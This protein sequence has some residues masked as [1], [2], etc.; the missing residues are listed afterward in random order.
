MCGRPS[1][2]LLTR[3]TTRPD[4]TNTSAVPLVAANSKPFLTNN[5][6]TS[7]AP[8]LSTS[9]TLNKIGTQHIEKNQVKMVQYGS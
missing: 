1:S 3:L 5:L 6:A 4:F 9:L 7:T 2:T 8:G